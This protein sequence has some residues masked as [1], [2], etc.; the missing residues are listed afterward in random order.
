[1]CLLLRA[2]SGSVMSYP[3]LVFHRR[4]CFLDNTNRGRVCGTRPS[5]PQ[6]AFTANGE[7]DRFLF[8]HALET[9]QPPSDDETSFHIRSFHASR[10]L[11][12]PF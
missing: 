6:P 2:G 11:A 4:S 7:Y 1:M 3:I 12:N 8:L 5:N 9:T 10:R